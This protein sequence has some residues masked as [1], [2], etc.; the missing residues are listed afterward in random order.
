MFFLL[1][2]LLSLAIG[3]A[4]LRH[5]L[6]DIDV[7]I[8]RTFQYAVLT[9]LLALV[10]LGM[11]VTLQSI[12]SIVGNQES[13]IF[14][15]ISTLVIAALFNPL[16]IRIQ[17]I[18]DRRFYRKKYEAEKALA[19]FATAA[20]D[21]VDL[22]QLSHALLEVVQETIQPSQVGFTLIENGET[23]LQETSDFLEATDV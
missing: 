21:E 1:P 22:N 2:V 23:T 11:I 5:R 8:R 4:I 3:I 7:I 10:Y 9:G 16:R 17:E 6:F 13:P 20:R 18:I 14:I 15:V 19:Q 12:F